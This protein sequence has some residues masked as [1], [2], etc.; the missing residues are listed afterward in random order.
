MAANAP[1]MTRICPPEATSRSARAATSPALRPR[2]V[3]GAS[4]PK[5][6]PSPREASAA[7]R[8]LTS[9]TG[10]SG[11]SAIPLTAGS[12]PWPGSRRATATSSP[13]IAGTASTYQPGGVVH[14]ALSGTVV[15]TSVVS[16]W[17]A[18]MK[19]AEPSATGTPSS[20]ATT[21]IRRY[22]PG[23]GASGGPAA[24]GVGRCGAGGPAAPGLDGCRLMVPFRWPGPLAGD[25][26]GSGRTSSF[27]DDVA[28][29]PHGTMRAPQPRRTGGARW[30]RSLLRKPGKAPGDIQ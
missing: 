10:D 20:A 16:P 13:A 28:L 5:T 18:L 1:A 6:N 30:L 14:P 9:W 8:A 4:G 26:R 19:A 27:L 24:P 25:H 23:D 11:S 21:R 7:S 29:P 2:A 17:T 12:P 15:H 3:S 22:S